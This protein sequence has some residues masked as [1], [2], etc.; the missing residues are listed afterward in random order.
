MTKIAVG[1]LIMF[2][3]T[4]SCVLFLLIIFSVSKG[5]SQLSKVHYIPPITDHGTGSTTGD[6]Y[7]YISTPSNSNVAYKVTPIGNPLGVTQGFV[8]NANPEKLP[9][10]TGVSQLILEYS[11]IGEVVNNKGYYI[12]ADDL[13]Y[14]SVRMNKDMSNTGTSYFQAG[15]LV[16][17]GM[18][19]LGQEFRVGSFTTPNSDDGHLSFFSILATEDNTI[20]N[21]DFPKIAQYINL[22]GT[23]PS[24]IILDEFESYTIAIE[25][26]SGN[27]GTLDQ[28]I[29]TLIQSD[30]PVVVNCGS[31]NGSFSET[32][33]GRDIGIDQ[34]VDVSRTG[35]E[36]ILVKGYGPDSIE[37]VLVVAHYDNTQISVNGFDIGITL[38]K[39]EYYSI[40]GGN[41]LN[42]NMYVQTTEDVFVFQ[43]TGLI[44]SGNSSA[45]NQGLFFVPP[46]SCEN[47]G[48]VN[49]IASIEKIGDTT[50][51]GALNLVVNKGVEVKINDIALNDLDTSISIDGPNDVLSL[52]YQTYVILGL[53]G[54]IKV[55]VSSGELYCSYFTQNG[56][57]TSGSFYSGFPL[58]PEIKFIPSFEQ[59]GNCIPNIVLEGAN[60]D[61]FDSFKWMFDDG[62][63]FTD[64]GVSS[65]TITPSSP[66]KYKLIGIIDCSGM[67]FESVEIPVSIC[68]SDS[69][70]DGIIDNIDLD[71]DND[72]ILDEVESLGNALLNLTDKDNPSISLNS[73]SLSS[74]SATGAYT[75]SSF[76][77]TTNSFTGDTN[78]NF[79]SVLIA[80]ASAQGVYTLSFTESVNVTIKPSNGSNH[81]YNEGE[82]F[83]IKTIPSNKNITLFNENNH[84]LIDTNYDGE[85]E[86][87]VTN[88]TN[89]EIRFVFNN[90]NIGNSYALNASEIEGI[91]LIHQSNNP[92][93]SSTFN[94]QISL[95]SLA[96]DTDGDL[97]PDA[98][99]EDSDGDGCFDTLEAGFSDDD[100]NGILGV[101]PITVGDRGRVLSQGGYAP[102]ANN[103]ANGTFD[104]Q[105]SGNAVNITNQ[106][107]AQSICSG[108]NTTFSVDTDTADAIYQ[109]QVKTTSGD[110]EDITS[111]AVYS[112]FNTNTLSL[113]AVPDTFSGNA[114]R[115]LVQSPTYQCDTSS[116]SNVVLNVNAVPNDAVV[117]P[118]QTFCNDNNPT[119]S[120]LVVVS[121]TNIEWYETETGG[122][123]LDPTTLLVHNKAYYALAKDA[124]GCESVNRIETTAFISNPE[125]SATSNEIC[126]GDS[127]MLTVNGIPKTPQDFIDAH[128]ELKKIQEYNGA[129][130]FVKEESMSWEDANIL[131]DNL[132]G[133]SMYII[134]D[135]A[136]EQTIYSGLQALGLTGDDDISFWFG[137]RQNLN[138]SSPGT[139][140]F[141]VDGT[142]LSYQN[143]AD[144]EPND[145]CGSLGEENNEENYGQ[146]EFDDNGMQWNDI[147]N[148]SGGNSWPLFEYTGTTDVVW[149]YLDPSTGNKVEIP[150]V[151]TSSFEVTPSETTTYFI[152]VTTNNVVCEN[153]FEV[154]V[155]P[156]PESNPADDIIECDNTTVGTA[157][158][159][160][161]N[162]FDLEA[163]TA[164]ILGSQAASGN[165]EV[166]YHLT[167]ED[168]NDASKVGLSSPFQNTVKDGQPIYIRVQNLTTGCFR[169]TESFNLVVNQLPESNP[170]DD[171]IE[172]DNTTVGTDIDGFINDFDLEARTAQILG[173]QAASGNFEVTYHLTPEDANDTSKVGLSS[174]FQNTVKDE[175]PIYIRVQNLTTGCFRATESFNLEVAPLPVL[176]N[177]GSIVIKQCDDEVT[178]DGILLTNLRFYESEL[179]QN[180]LNE[181]FEYFEDPSF[182][183]SSKIID[184][185]QY[186]NSNS[187]SSQDIHVKITTANGC[188]RNALIELRVGFNLIKN[189]SLVPMV[190][191]EDSPPTNQDGI[192]VFPKEFF[193]DLR[194]QIEAS[195]P[196]FGMYTSFIIEFY[197]SKEDASTKMNPID[198]TVDY[199]N[200]TPWTQKIW[201][202]IENEELG[203]FECLGLEQ[204]AELTV[205][206]LPVAHP[207]T[208]LK[209][210]DDDQDGEFP[211]DTSDIEAELLQGQTGVTI[212]Y[213]DKNGN[214]LPSPLPNPFTTHSQIITIT[215]ENSPSNVATACSDSTTLEFIVDD[216]PVVYS[217]NIPSQC[218]DGLDDTDDY[219]EFD[220]SNIQADLLGGQ[221]GMIVTYT[222]RN[223]NPLDSP[224]PNPFNTQTQTITATVVNPKNTNCS[225]TLDIEFIV[226]KLPTFEV[227]GDQIV[228][229][230]LPAIP[231]EVFT[232]GTYSYSWTRT[233]AASIITSLPETTSK[234]FVNQG[235]IYTV[236]AITTDGT[237]CE[238][239]KEILVK[240]S[241]IASIDL[242]SIEVNDLSNNGTN[243][244]AISTSDLGVGDY[245]FALDNDS[246]PYQD[247]PLFENV[248]PGIHTVYIQD[249]NNCGIEQIDVSVIGYPK[250][251]TPNGD[252]YNDRWNILG[253]SSQFQ[254]TSKIY[255]FDRFGKLIKEI[256]PLGLGW[257]GNYLGKPLPASDYWFRV[258]LEDGREFKGHFTL[259][260]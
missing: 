105:E 125:I 192:S 26:G 260:R 109:W 201:A 215:V 119:V 210:C 193:E 250:Y 63:G 155:K 18:A 44:F 16:S 171:I 118:I 232:S 72:G 223:G 58:A 99:D 20:I 98:F 175:Q 124:L 206:R 213:T 74:I 106:P 243:T 228:C 59:L 257:D 161:I 89:S 204:V 80:D 122:T 188:V 27:I 168:A 165:F 258:Y 15:A 190:V 88:F 158:D 152:E 40:E 34:I 226:D 2:K 28:L 49:N 121:G 36:Y 230:N 186:E 14:V 135:L 141:W 149:G 51:V 140:W 117:E 108:G 84:L 55:S 259:K 23:P 79:S 67:S 170:A 184:P 164:Q 221:T 32:L 11:K 242:S 61:V 12:Q 87:G 138:A 91:E 217:V 69:D 60:T 136:E 197:E 144:D 114:Y 241:N 207:V 116:N 43:G 173:S 194:N 129:Y 233:D 92:I 189:F 53:T 148:N 10:G 46:L 177:S 183:P 181:N 218:D 31:S 151:G 93:D 146:F 253:V 162:D 97:I 198:D 187:P 76:S 37:N 113:T 62:S 65:A 157:T 110:W 29:G 219:S 169:A 178:N 245:E 216:T 249:K 24:S 17:K 239:S 78:G 234:I 227:D 75:S 48:N 38:N 4:K 199:S 147:P 195:N 247:D 132:E 229:L 120:N 235:G 66:G 252:G 130:Y 156:L 100:L 128:P 103:N 137:L 127:I 248:A 107:V 159:G 214:A 33:G 150:D 77:G 209:E 50:F 22:G 255:I 167:P 104:F 185:T 111:T 94:A 225:M 237:L 240:E 47:K 246:G 205:E 174:P 54:N 82:K 224:L 57:A 71:N 8:S 145:C 1:V 231:I 86:S 251:F 211:F 13:V 102:P 5:N 166:T 208:T 6:Q 180:A 154:V 39:G 163:R 21:F 70:S 142:P 131:G 95:Y 172:C 133:T 196:A 52:D 85:Y 25:G 9:I 203:T 160:F 134:N 153:T 202:N 238:R 41:F 115:V 200:S 112:D 68:P 254:S 42:G 179:S 56:P 182:D 96:V 83:S 30:K 7:L 90:N 73:G 191:C 126:L 64:T 143:W 256:H 3:L 212:S 222:D 123:P 101:D 244:I 45:A 19:A 236:T 176:K 139:G 35:K 220:T 81:S